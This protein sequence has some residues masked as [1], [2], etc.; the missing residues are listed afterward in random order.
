M[1]I[2]SAPPVHFPSAKLRWAAS[3]YGLLV[4]LVLPA[5]IIALNDDFGY[6]RSVVQTLQHGRPWTDDW[7][8]PWAAGFSSLSAGLFLATGSFYFAT[9]GL[10][11]LLA[12]VAFYAA[13]R[14]LLERGLSGRASLVV[15][16]LGLT[17]PTVFWKALE[18]TGG[19]L[20]VPCLLLALWLAG[21]RRW[22][23]FSLVWALALTT[24]Q[25]ALAWV[26]LPAVAVLHSWRDERAAPRRWLGPAVVAAGGAVL[27]FCMS[28]GMNKTHAQVLVTDHM[29]DGWTLTG[30]RVVLLTGVAVWLVAGG[31]GA[32]TL[33]LARRREASG[34]SRP[35]WPAILAALACL[36]LV[37]VDFRTY[38]SFDHDTFNHPAGRI[39]GGALI[40]L[41]AAGWLVQPVRLRWSWLP[42]GLAALALV[43]LRNYAWDYYLIDV[44]VAGFFGLLPAASP[45]PAAAFRWN[46]MAAPVLAAMV[47][48]HVF[49]VLQFKVKLDQARAITVLS[50][51]VLREKILPA[52]AMS[53]MPFGVMGWH[54]HPYYLR[55]EGA[56]SGDLAG[57]G[58]YLRGHTVDINREY[59]PVLR[60]LPWFRDS[61]PADRSQ[62]L[63]QAR[64]PFCW[65]F[66]EDN[67]VVRVAADKVEPART[68]LGADYEPTVFPL[69]DAEWREFIHPRP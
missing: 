59:S 43:G 41:A 40:G 38:L 19:A 67:F 63:L 60:R 42:F 13:G 39:Y 16:F 32:L 31:L 54:F 27:Y 45:A 3:A 66:H 2:T 26:V 23:W 50:S 22:G 35:A 18:F 62:V 49:F 34:F 12:G 51:R 37:P 5:G 33:A 20:Y 46:R 65:F 15:A 11:A 21:Q 44:A 48:L 9:Y 55:H 58:R 24:R 28:R 61:P 53:F 8:E 14:L 30:A 10:L 56:T 4:F 29:L 57:F 1:A 7:L 52:D 6:L 17:F 69:N 36:A 47:A 64:F 25:S 68:P